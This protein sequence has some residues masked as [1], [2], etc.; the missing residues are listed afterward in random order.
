MEIK[1]QKPINLEEAMSNMLYGIETVPKAKH[2]PAE[3]LSSERKIV[4]IPFDK[5]VFR[6][7]KYRLVNESEKEEMTASIKSVGVLHPP[8]VRP[9]ENGRFEVISGRNRTICAKEAGLPNMPCE[10]QIMDDVTANLAVHCANLEGRSG[11]SVMERAWGYR[12][13]YDTLKDSGNNNALSEIV[14]FAETKEGAGSGKDLRKRIQRYLRYTYLI[15]RLGN[16]VDT[17]EL[18]KGAAYDLS[19]ISEDNQETI[20]DYFAKYKEEY[21]PEIAQELRKYCETHAVLSEE[22]IDKLLYPP[23]ISKKEKKIKVKKTYAKIDLTELT[24][25]LTQKGLLQND[26]IEGKKQKEINQTIYDLILNLLQ[27]S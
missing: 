27:G 10:I 16:L 22:D 13:L 21:N 5:L 12:E 23:N 19:F 9:V 1:P 26:Q 2:V 15:D 8:I 4:S 14:K 6:D 17:G 25:L 3:E 11:L 18:S 24:P 7:Q 20:A